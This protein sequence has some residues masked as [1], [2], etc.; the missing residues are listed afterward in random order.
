MLYTSILNIDNYHLF[1]KIHP[2]KV[3]KTVKCLKMFSKWDLLEHLAMLQTSR[4]D[5]DFEIV[6]FPFHDEDVP[7]SPFLWCIYFATYLFCESVF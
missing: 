2:F 1:S 3:L 6:N 5:F 4:D 7:L